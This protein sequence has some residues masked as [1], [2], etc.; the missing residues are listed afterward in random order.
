MIENFLEAPLPQKKKKIRMRHWWFEKVLFKVTS[1]C[2]DKTV[3]RQ[4][5]MANYD[6]YFYDEYDGDTVKKNWKKHLIYLT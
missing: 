1:K 6:F 2:V 5:N 4:N 3:R